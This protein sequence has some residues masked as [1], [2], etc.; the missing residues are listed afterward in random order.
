MKCKI[1]N[2]KLESDTMPGVLSIRQHTFVN[3]WSSG[4]LLFSGNSLCI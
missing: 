4:I 2:L 3:D 1:L